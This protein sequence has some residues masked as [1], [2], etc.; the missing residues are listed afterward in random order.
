MM[1]VDRPYREKWNYD[2]FVRNAGLTLCDFFASTK[3][4]SPYEHSLNLQKASGFFTYMEPENIAAPSWKAGF[5]FR[6]L[7]LKAPKDLP[8]LLAYDFDY[9]APNKAT[10]DLSEEEIKQY[11]TYVSESR[12]LDARVGFYIPKRSAE[13][14]ILLLNSF[15]WDWPTIY[16]SIFNYVTDD[17]AD[18]NSGQVIDLILADV[19]SRQ[20]IDRTERSYHASDYEVPDDRKVFVK[21][22]ALK[23]HDFGPL[24]SLFE[25][26]FSWGID[27]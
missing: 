11:G 10:S 17:F 7:L 18:S 14:G 22:S 8:F 20:I 2:Y 3:G 12:D 19:N 23:P 13:E 27:L 5:E 15:K 26:R 25:T 4:A 1:V 24:A 21:R 16:G 9:V 6:C